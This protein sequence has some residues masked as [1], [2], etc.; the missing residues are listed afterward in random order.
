MNGK[1]AMDAYSSALSM[2]PY[3]LEFLADRDKELEAQLTKARARSGGEAGMHAG[4]GSG[5]RDERKPAQSERASAERNQGRYG[6]EISAS[7]AASD[8]D[9]PATDDDISE[10]PDFLRE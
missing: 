2:M 1:T 6:G 4:E 5:W 8:I 3:W 9:R 10:K 7:E